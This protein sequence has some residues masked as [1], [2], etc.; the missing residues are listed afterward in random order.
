MLTLSIYD[1]IMN[2]NS[3]TVLVTRQHKR[4]RNKLCFFIHAINYDLEALMGKKD[5]FCILKPNSFCKN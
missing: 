5:T 2:L 1:K 3:H 4:E